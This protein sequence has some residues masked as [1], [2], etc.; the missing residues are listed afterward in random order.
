M[1]FS[2]FLA[3][4]SLLLKVIF[5]HVIHVNP[6]STMLCVWNEM[7]ASVTCNIEV[8]LFRIMFLQLWTSTETSVWKLQTKSTCN[9]KAAERTS[10]INFILV[11]HAWLT[12]V[13]S[14]L[15]HYNGICINNT[16]VSYCMGCVSLLLFVVS[17]QHC[18]NLLVLK[19]PGCDFK[20]EI[21]NLI[22]LIVTFRSYENTLRWMP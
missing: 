5:I 17:I 7:L 15:Y 3:L 12:N 1:L 4:L 21:F 11:Y 6:F 20:H 22:L 8:L 2:K 16:P 14:E 19:R 18:I 10:W 13:L 9:I